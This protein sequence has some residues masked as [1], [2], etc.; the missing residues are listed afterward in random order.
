[1]FDKPEGMHKLLIGLD[2]KVSDQVLGLNVPRT[3]VL[4]HRLRDTT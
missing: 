1:M 4:G 3:Q 2:Q